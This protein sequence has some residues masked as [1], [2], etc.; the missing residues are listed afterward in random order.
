M[1][2]TNTVAAEKK[3]VGKVEF[4][5]Y[6]AAVFF[7]TCMTGMLGSYRSAYLVNVLQLESSQTSLFNTIISIVPFIMHFFVAMYI[8]NRKIGKSGK[9]RPL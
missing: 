7:Y 9:F 3:Y 1:S 2:E 4:I 8:D 5:T 6:L